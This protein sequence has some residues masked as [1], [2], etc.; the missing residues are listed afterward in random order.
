MNKLSGF[1]ILWIQLLILSGPL[2][3]LSQSAKPQVGTDS[4]W[5]PSNIASFEKEVEKLR[6]EYHIPG[7]SVGIVQNKQLSWTKGFGFADIE[8]KIVPDENTVYQIASLSKT[9]A[10]ILLMQQVELGKVDLDDPIKKYGINLGGRW[11][12]DERIKVKH[13]LTHT[14]MG[15]TLNGFKPGYIFRYNGDWYAQLKLVIEKSSGMSY[16]NLL[17]KN[18]IW[19]VGLKN[20]VPSTNDSID[21]KLT[22]Y[23]KDSFLTK[24]AKPYDWEKKQLSP[25]KYKYRFGAAAG[26]MSCVSDLALYSIAIDEKKFL[27]PETWEKV[28]TP[29]VT[30]SGKTIQ[31]GL[32][33]F[34]KYYKG[35]KIVWHTGWWMGYSALIVKIPEK[36]LTFIILANSQD[37]SR[38][39]YNIVQPIPGFGFYEPFKANLNNTLL[40]SAFAKSF[41]K[42]F[43]GL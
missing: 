24:V 9:F 2:K 14:A 40:G 26:I 16:G 3:V 13:L 32:G 11:G 37:L 30:P 42:H 10:S 22:G 6:V 15:N 43:A 7:L 1:I 12:S 31:Y 19:P 34:V 41:L 17:L 39:F 8:K 18:I 28:F 33:W 25:V 38:P 29:Y 5:S 23:D 35:V 21:F 27:K 20:T 36:D 4:V